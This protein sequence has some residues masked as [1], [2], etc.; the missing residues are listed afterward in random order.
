[1][2][3]LLR[4]VKDATISTLSTEVRMGGIETWRCA[5]AI[6]MQWWALETPNGDNAGGAPVRLWLAV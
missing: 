4:D 3:H 5:V 2:E 6:C 1:M